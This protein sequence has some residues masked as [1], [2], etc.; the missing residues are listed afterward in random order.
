MGGCRC[1]Y[2]NC[3]NSTKTTENVH[4]F[5]YPVKHKERC[6]MWIDNARKP[7]FLHL[8]EDQ[9]RN[10][11]ICEKHFE[12]RCF[13]N[14]QKKRLLQGAIPTLD[15]DSLE[16]T[17]MESN[18]Y[19]L[20]ADQNDIKVLPANEDGTC[21]LLDTESFKNKSGKVESF[22][23]ENGSIVPASMT[24]KHSN[25]LGYK[26]HNSPVMLNSNMVKTFVSEPM[27]E[28]SEFHIKEEII[29][30]DNGIYNVQQRPPK[31]DPPAKSGVEK[32]INK[33]YLRKI[34]QHS[35]E[36]A[37]IKKILEQKVMTE[38]KPDFSS[39]LLSVKDQLPPTLLTILSLH[40]DQ[41]CQLSEDDIEFF[42]TIYNTSPELYSILV[43]KYNWNLPCVEQSD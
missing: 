39:I 24:S 11:V 20:N 16:E 29:E 4:F 40:L 13:P 8:E 2:R 35:R 14:L 41:Q 32:N 18:L 7:Q 43:E 15:G 22:V 42:T 19:L 10:K 17:T 9:L 37:S 28:V 26:S 1:S 12:D 27:E 30:E 3:T 38:V 6:K 5:H 31:I 23:Y 21:F 33:A 36:I 34:N 25:P